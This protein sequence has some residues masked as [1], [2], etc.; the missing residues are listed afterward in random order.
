M[1]KS[2]KSK[3]KETVD[4]EPQL[5]EIMDTLEELYLRNLLFFRENYPK[6]Y[7]KLEKLHIQ[8]ESGAIDP[9]YRIELNSS[10]DALD[11]HD[12]ENDKFI[13]DEDI[14]EYAQ[15]KLD[16]C[17][18]KKSKQIVFIGSLLGTHIGLISKEKKCKNIMVFEENYEIFRLSLFVTDYKSMT[19]KAKLSFSIG[20]T[21]DDKKT[22]KRFSKF[23]ENS[24]NDEDTQVVIATTH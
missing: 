14:Y 22:Q 16:K 10:T 24:Q 2:N 21:L 7:K 4:I 15:N 23:K 19:K 13:Y 11:L 8:L 12:I 6:V 9:Q 20:N 1:K 5:I 18:F 3:Q 17:E